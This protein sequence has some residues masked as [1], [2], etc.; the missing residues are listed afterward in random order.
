MARRK[1]GGSNWHKARIQV[2]RIHEKTPMPVMIFY[3][4]DP[5][6]WCAKTK[7]SISKTYK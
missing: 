6:N 3:L 5:R 2:A 4:S 1:K 7:S